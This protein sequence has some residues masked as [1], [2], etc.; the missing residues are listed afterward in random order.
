MKRILNFGSLNIDYVYQLDHFIRPG[1][2]TQSQ[3]LSVFCGDKGLNQSIALARAGATVFH[4]G[5]SGADDG[6]ALLNELSKVGVNMDNIQFV[7]TRSGN[8]IIQVDKDGE[9]AIIL[10]CGANH[11]ITENKIEQTLARFNDNDILLLQNEIN[12][13]DV[14]IKKASEK[15]LTVVLNPSPCNELIRNLPLHLVDVFILNEIEGR[16]LTGIGGAGVEHIMTAMRE[17]FPKA[18]IVLTLGKFGSIYFDGVNEYRQKTFNV[19]VVDT[20]V[21]GDTFTGYFLAGFAKDEPSSQIIETASKA[22]AIAVSRAGASIS[23][24]TIDEVLSSN[25]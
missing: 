6:H 23:I 14:L 17:A 8:A 1:E 18:R 3:S 7:E 25:C 2:T 9:N 16:D 11:C 10:F 12:C 19:P 22:A 4:A 15:G 13:T 20:T 24:P 21:A 5:C